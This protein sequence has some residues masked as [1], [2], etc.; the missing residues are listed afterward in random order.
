MLKERIPNLLGGVSLSC[1]LIGV[2]AATPAA[3]Q[4]YNDEV[5]VTAT[6]RAESVQDVAISVTALSEKQIKALGYTNAQQITAMAPGV[7]TVQPNGES[8]YSVAIRGASNSDFTT[9]VESP[10]ALYV[11]ET[12]ISQSSGSGFQLFDTE[13]V[14]ILR[15]PQGTLFGRNATGGLVHYISVKPQDEFGGYI[16]GS[17]GSY[18]RVKLQGAMNLPVSEDVAARVSFA[19]NQGDGYVENRLRPDRDLNNANDFAG[20]AQLKFEPSDNF[21]LLLAARYGKQDIRT[22]FFEYVSAPDPTGAGQPTS[23]NPA[24][25]GMSILTEMSTPV[26]MISTGATSLKLIAEQLRQNIALTTMLNLQ[27]LLI[28]NL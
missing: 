4:V 14:E 5:I 13:R 18:N 6:K 23:P 25:G 17:F 7:S 8:N 1:L 15:G 3:A 20:R 28:S 9:N 11:D 12:Y 26:P 19:S 21:D 2:I 16:Y 24:L 22:G 27:A 10:V